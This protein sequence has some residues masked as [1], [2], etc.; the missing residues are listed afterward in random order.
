MVHLPI[1]ARK[2]ER[3]LYHS[4]ASLAKYNDRATLKHRLMKLVRDIAEQHHES[5]NF[6]NT[7]A[8]IQKQNAQPPSLF[9]NGFRSSRRGGSVTSQSSV[10]SSSVMSQQ[11]QMILNRNSFVSTASIDSLRDLRESVDTKATIE[12]ITSKIIPSS[13]SRANSVSSKRSAPMGGENDS[14]V[15]NDTTIIDKKLKESTDTFEMPA[16]RQRVR[17]TNASTGSRNSTTSL[18][19]ASETEAFTMGSISNTL[20]Q[21]PPTTT[22]EEYRR[23]QK[24]MNQSLQEQILD[25]IRLQEEI[26]R[27]IEQTDQQMILTN[28]RSQSHIY[29]T[30]QQQQYDPL[31]LYMNNIH[32]DA[33]NINSN[34]NLGG[35]GIIS[36]NE[37]MSS[38]SIATTNL[39]NG[40]RI[41]AS[42]PPSFPQQQHS[43]SQQYT[44]YNNILSPSFLLLQ[45][46]Q[47]LHQ[48]TFLKDNSNARYNDVD[49]ERNQVQLQQ[50]QVQSFGGASS[51]LQQNYYN[52]LLR[53]QQLPSL[54][55]LQ[56][57]MPGITHSNN[58][59][60]MGQQLLHNF[61][62]NNNSFIQQQQLSMQTQLLNRSIPSTMPNMSAADQ[63]QVR[64]HS[65]SENSSMSNTNVSSVTSA[66]G[67]Q[68]QPDVEQPNPP[69]Q[70]SDSN[71]MEQFDALD[72]WK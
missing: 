8:Q 32:D 24:L 40:S 25:N 61:P 36:P 5:R 14:T 44:D 9:G 4:A 66:N 2:L 63:T 43:Q 37:I 13:I 64:M 17:S 18:S 51:Q 42:N 33:S 59:L 19:I 62:N 55:S 38:S 7:V 71:T 26:V 39:A 28:N 50:Q 56:G 6:D 23:Q 34:V 72:W 29:N 46:Q 67:T 49:S 22:P 31:P 27:K 21:P 41:G 68:Q 60:G 58:N 65:L 57:L 10:E 30:Q 69:Y 70:P 54:P 11:Q 3:R 35:H 45:Q 16:P 1:K 20:L 48:P 47:Q 15:H 53:Q 52:A 12:P